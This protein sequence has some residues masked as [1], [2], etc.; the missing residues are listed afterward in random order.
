MKN[1][2]WTFYI[3]TV[4]LSFVYMPI[5]NLVLHSICFITTCFRQ[6]RDHI[7]LKRVVAKMEAKFLKYWTTIPYLYSFAFILDPEWRCLFDMLT[8]IGTHMSINYIETI[9][10][11]YKEEFQFE[12]M[13]APEVYLGLAD[14]LVKMTYK[15]IANLR[16]GSST[17]QSLI[18]DYSPSSQNTKVDKY[19]ATPWV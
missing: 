17:G 8:L 1:C 18:I 7:L 13:Q 10:K 19:L 9:Y 16:S 4:S 3:E 5:S 14:S 11:A 12:E 6:H 2:L 15:Q